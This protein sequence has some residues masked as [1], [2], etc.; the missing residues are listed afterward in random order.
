MAGELQY[1]VTDGKLLY[2]ESG[3]SIGK[4]TYECC[5]DDSQEINE[6]GGTPHPGCDSCSCCNADKYLVCISG[7]TGD[8]ADVNDDG[9][10]WELSGISAGEYKYEDD[11]VKIELSLS[12]GTWSDCPCHDFALT[13]SESDGEGGWNQC[14][15]A[16]WRFGEGEEDDAGTCSQTGTT[17]GFSWEVYP[18][19]IWTPDQVTVTF[20]GITIDY[21]CFSDAPGTSWKYDLV[22]NPNQSYTLHRQAGTSCT[23]YGEVPMMGNTDYYADEDDCTGDST[24]QYMVLRKFWA[25]IS[26][27][28][29]P[30]WAVSAQWDG[31]GVQPPE[32]SAGLHPVFATSGDGVSGDCMNGTD[33]AISN[34]YGS[35]DNPIY[36]GTVTVTPVW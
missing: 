36:G 23:W 33:S 16:D 6:C 25:S 5:C 31:S 29:D 20:S 10:G 8:C 35:G 12:S 2:V 9:G 11:D 15:T 3:T 19:R 21:S 13:A 26:G 32:Y 22:P 28:T 4:L 34:V 24:E 1:R 14:F 18:R 17:D 27:D 7:G 30:K